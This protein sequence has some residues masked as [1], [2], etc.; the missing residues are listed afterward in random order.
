M[1]NSLKIISSECKELSDSDKQKQ[2]EIYKLKIRSAVGKLNSSTPKEVVKNLHWIK[3]KVLEKNNDIRLLHEC[4]GF[5]QLFKALSSPHNEVLNA[6]LSFLGNFCTKFVVNNEI[7]R[8]I[9]ES[10]VASKLLTI[11]RE[12]NDKNIK[13][14]LC[15]FVGNLAQSRIVSQDLHRAALPAALILSL[16]NNEDV[17][18]QQMTIRALRWMWESERLHGEM[19]KL[20][21]VRAVSSFLDTDNEE[22]LK[23]VLRSLVVFTQPNSQEVAVQ[24][25]NKKGNGYQMIVSKLGV[26]PLTSVLVCNL[27]QCPFARIELSKAGVVSSIV[28]TLQTNGDNKLD[29]YLI[30]SLCNMCRESMVRASLRNT[31]NGFKTLLSLLMN[32]SAK[33]FYFEILHAITQFNY[34]EHSL[35]ILVKGGLINVLLT[36]LREYT[37]ENGTVHAERIAPR[38][39]TQ[40]AIPI[41]PHSPPSH[42]QFS[43]PRSIS[44]PG[45]PPA[46][47]DDLETAGLLFSPKYEPSDGEEDSITQTPSS[48]S[49]FSKCSSNGNEKLLETG[50]TRIDSCIL[51]TLCQLTYQPQPIRILG[52]KTTVDTL[53]EYMVSLPYPQCRQNYVKATKTLSSIVT[54]KHYFNNLLEEECVLAIDRVLCRPR[55]NDCWECS[56]LR[57]T[58]RYILQELAGSAQSGLGEGEMTYRL[59]TSSQTPLSITTA[60]SVPHVIRQPNLLNSLLFGHRAL[61]CLLDTLNTRIEEAVPSLHNLFTTLDVKNPQVPEQICASCEVSAV[62]HESNVTFV[63][64]DGFRVG[65]NK[66]SLEHACPV[67]EAMFRGG[68]M[69][70]NLSQVHLSE[71]TADCLQYL[72]RLTTSGEFCSCLLPNDINTLLEMVH[73]T[74]RFC[75]PDLTKKV[76]HHIMNNRLSADTSPHIYHWGIATGRHLPIASNVPRDVVK[77]L[78]SALDISAI[79]RQIAVHEII[80]SEQKD[81]FFNEIIQVVKEGFATYSKHY[82]LS[83]FI[84]FNIRN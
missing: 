30:T 25:C 35:K 82:R 21:S 79:S 59:A 81:E 72:I 18:V 70:S 44:P 34:D 57:D 1:E 23:L 69:E 55:H 11:L 73:Q 64:D 62:R 46:L 24:I 32:P 28:R 77:Y 58:G 8:E 71:I 65:A 4:G 38:E 33:Q 31:E 60:L 29:S 2:L 9:T 43:P 15:R 22:L 41:Q 45:S 47:S 5:K 50:S 67:F 61:H 76:L 16:E 6:V 51:E 3:V 54:C 66:Q 75:L 78:L 56:R 52:S 40:G 10:K 48:S 14:R 74:D 83:A 19:L 26:I 13:I 27:S 68:F 42:Y 63:T 20:G 12:N 36:R 37:E 53:L 80:K 84:F 39:R 49:S 7:C 17:E